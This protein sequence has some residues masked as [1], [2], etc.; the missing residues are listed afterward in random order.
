M[1]EQRLR[2]LLVDD[3]PDALDT[4]SAFLEVQ[5][6]EVMTAADG[7]EAVDR[8]VSERPDLIIMDLSLPVVS[9]FDAARRLR[10]LP[11]TARIPLIAATGY[12]AAAQIEDA[13]RA[14]FDVV[15]I[16]PVD[17]D[18]LMREVTRLLDAARERDRQMRSDVG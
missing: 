15:L 17:P 13:G 11:E 7:K 4:W 1:N 12:S 10:S 16:K 8:A 2:L 5:G 3:Y 18:E 14:G 9:G 6:Y